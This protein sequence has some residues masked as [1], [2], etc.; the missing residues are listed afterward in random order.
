MRRRP[1][2]NF[3]LRVSNTAI[4]VAFLMLLSGC[5]AAPAPKLSVALFQNRA[6]YATRTLEVEITNRGDTDVVIT[7][8]SFT[9]AFF[10]GS[11]TAGHLPYTLVAGTTTDFPATVPPVTQARSIR[12]ASVSA[13]NLRRWR[14]RFGHKIKMDTPSRPPFASS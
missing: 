9:S 1:M 13:Q 2:N 6:D 4:A 7:A 3:P 5:S 10:E 8:A 11:G 14:F 12:A